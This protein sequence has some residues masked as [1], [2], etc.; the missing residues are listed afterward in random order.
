MHIKIKEILPQDI[1]YSSTCIYYLQSCII[2][3]FSIILNKTSVLFTGGFK[4]RGHE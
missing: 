1:I 2:I 4:T 3:Y